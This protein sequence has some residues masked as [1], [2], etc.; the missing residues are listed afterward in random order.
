[1]LWFPPLKC[2][3]LL[4]T[5]GVVVTELMEVAVFLGGTLLIS[6]FKHVF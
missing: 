1:M 6:A 5:L 4:K 2:H 3:L